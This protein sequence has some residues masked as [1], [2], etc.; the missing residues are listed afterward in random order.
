[1][2]KVSK[3]TAGDRLQLSY[4]HGGVAQFRAGDTLGP[5]VLP[6]YE[7]V[8]IIEG[9]VKYDADGR[10]NQAPAGSIL[11][12]RPGFHETYNWDPAGPTRHAYFHFDILQIPQRWPE[13]SGWPIVQTRPDSVLPS[14]FRH[15]LNRIYLHQDWPAMPPAL[16]DCL[17]VE[18]LLSLFVE[19]DGIQSTDFERDRPVQVNLAINFTR[20][21]IDTDPH[22]LLSL[23]E[24]A[25]VGGVSEKHLC[26][27]FQ[28]SLGHSPMH[29]YRL[30]CL[31]LALPLLTRSNLDIQEIADRC[32]FDDPAYF[33]RYFSKVFGCS[34]SQ[35]RERLRRGVL[36]PAS[37]LPVDLTPRFFW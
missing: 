33:S 27:S 34:P 4:L 35:V 20:E 5:R 19:R 10:Q 31:Q 7:L 12:T 23:K 1:M 2:I 16:V 9:N 18:T 36:P 6:D 15:V 13:L 3:L 14:L 28:K 26:R 8:L 37:P 17:V 11:F 32:G 21:V 24:L 29:T 22:R 25:R 30:L